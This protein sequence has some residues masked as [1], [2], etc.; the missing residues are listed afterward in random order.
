MDV[1]RRVAKFLQD[2]DDEQITVN[3]HIDLMND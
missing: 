1:F 3:D 2:N